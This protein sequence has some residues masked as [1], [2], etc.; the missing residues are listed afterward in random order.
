MSKIIKPDAGKKIFMDDAG[1]L[2]IPDD[3]IIP[4]IQGDGIGEDIWKASVRVFDS[5]VKKEFQYRLHSRPR[6]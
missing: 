6:Y 2:N 1:K 3:P 4:F 5:A